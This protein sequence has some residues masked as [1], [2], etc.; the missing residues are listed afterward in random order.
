MALFDASRRDFL[1]ESLAAGS[2]AVLASPPCAAKSYPAELVARTPSGFAPLAR[3]GVVVEARARAELESL[4]QPNRLWPRPEPARSLLEA[5]LAELSGQPSLAKGLG[6][7]IHPDDRVA[8][9]VNGIAGPAMATNAELIWPLVEG[10]LEIGVSPERIAVYEQYPNFLSATRVGSNPSRLPKGVRLG[11]HNNHRTSMQRLAVYQEIP[12]Q[13][14][15]FLTESTAVINV[16]L[17]KDHS[18]AGYTGALKNMTHGSIVNPHD[19]HR[20]QADP[21]IAALYA[22]PILRSRVRLHITDGF[23]LIYDEGP[24]DKN[25]RRR[26]LHGT[27]HAATDPVSLDTVGLEIVNQ[28][29]KRNGLPLLSG[30][31]RPANYLRAAAELGLGVGERAAIDVRA[32]AV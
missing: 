12:T 18:I 26:I 2:A 10:L 22:H 4:M 28:A 7:F 15:S 25:P 14:V 1:L 6:K 17:L 21:Q 31:G 23:K 16:S 3:P 32:V 27:V 5:A 9:K 24:L 8:I 13:Y 11:C 19:H 30:A 29:R 20:H